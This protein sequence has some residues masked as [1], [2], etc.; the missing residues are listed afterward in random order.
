MRLNF[1]IGVDGDIEGGAEEEEVVVE[2]G[3]D[4]FEGC[5]VELGIVVVVVGIKN[6]WLFVGNE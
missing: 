6:V 4:T 1:T 5:S 2:D 3:F